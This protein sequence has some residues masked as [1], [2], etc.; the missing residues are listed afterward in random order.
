MNLDDI[1]PNEINQSQKDIHGEIPLTE[2]SLQYSR[3]T[4]VGSRTGRDWDGKG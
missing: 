4:E 3:F 2:V 1:M